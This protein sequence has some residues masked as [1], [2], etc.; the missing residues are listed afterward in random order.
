LSIRSWARKLELRSFSD[1]SEDRM[2]IHQNARLTPH[3]RALIVRQV[4]G[5]QTP[6]ATARAAGV[7]PRTVRKWVARFAAEVA[8]RAG[9]G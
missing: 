8:R 4:A 3:G 7:C 5:G 1:A 6:E 9:V 2:N